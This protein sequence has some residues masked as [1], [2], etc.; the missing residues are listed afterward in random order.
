MGSLNTSII[1]QKEDISYYLYTKELNGTFINQSTILSINFDT[2]K[3]TI[4]IIHGWKT[5]HSSKMPQMVKD[6]YLASRDVNI[7]IVDWS[8]LSYETY[9][10]SKSYVPQIGKIVADFILFMNRYVRL[11]IEKTAFVGFSLGAHIAGNT[12]RMIGGSASHLVGEYL[13][14]KYF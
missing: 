11:R 1:L 3:E 9:I 13:L 14:F 8:I 2:R 4:F 7:I 10:T 12:G 5:L 6:A